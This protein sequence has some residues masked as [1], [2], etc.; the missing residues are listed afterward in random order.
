M[1]PGVRSRRAAVGSPEW[2]GELLGEW[3]AREVAAA[4]AMR[5]C[6]GL[7]RE[8]IEDI[9]QDSVEKL[10]PRSFASEEHLRNALRLAMRFRALN[11]HRNERGRRRRLEE[12]APGWRAAAQERASDFGPEAAALGQQ[13]RLIVAEFLTE[14]DPQEQR[15]FWHEAEGL[16][17]RAIAQMLGIEINEARRVS[18]SV[19]KKRE[20]F[21]LLYDTGRLCGFRS[22]TIQALQ[23]GEAK[24]EELA[25]RAFA[26]LDSC[27]RCRAEHKTNAQ[28]LRARF[29]G[30]AIALLPLPALAD[31]GG[32]VGRVAGRL[33]ALAARYLPELPSLSGGGSV[34]EQAVGLIAGGSAVAKVTAGAV[35]AVVIAGGAV[36]AH[37]LAGSGHEHRG[38]GNRTASET[39]HPHAAARPAAVAAPPVIAVVKPSAASESV[40]GSASPTRPRVRNPSAGEAQRNAGGFA[41]LGVPA[42]ASAAS[43]RASAP[44]AQASHSNGGGEFSP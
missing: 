21:Q 7:R 38:H 16:R 12:S 4:G 25:A 15:V 6:R 32:F 29:E 26:H 33:R 41:Y 44:T 9:Y 23:R 18:R 36:G 10:L 43:T 27:A 37:V 13:D 1:P 19:E 11:A 30:E 24:S 40:T 8:Q 17:Y 2:V 28:L 5:E 3:K 34:R 14:L 22:A 20:R 35:S 31:H 39:V 42:R